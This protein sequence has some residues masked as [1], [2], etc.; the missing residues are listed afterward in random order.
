M[1]A[2]DP[3]EKARNREIAENEKRRQAIGA[4]RVSGSAIAVA[5]IIGA[6]VVVIIWAW[7]HR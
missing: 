4:I 7:T 1:S 2:S 6:I 5:F 3:D